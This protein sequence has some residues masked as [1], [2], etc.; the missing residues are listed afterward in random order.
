MTSVTLKMLALSYFAISLVLTLIPHVIWLMSWI[1]GKCF[2]YSLP[3]SPFGKFTLA[4]LA[5]T[6]LILCYGVFVGR[7]K[8]RTTSFDY[9]NSMVPSEFD[10][11]RVV[12]I[13]DLHLSTFDDGKKHLEKA[14]GMINAL[15]ADLVCF[16]GDM[17][18]LSPSETEPYVDVL[19]GVKARDG[20]VSVLGN[21]DFFIYSMAKK[22]RLH[23]A[24]GVT[25]DPESSLDSLVGFERDSLGWRLLRNENM[26]ISRGEGKI[27]IVGVDNI[28]GTDQG[29]KTIAKG[30]LRKAMEGTDGFR[31][32]LSHDPSHWS[33]EVVPTTDIP[34]T[35]SGHTHAAQVRIFGW[36]P[37]KWVFRHTDGRYDID[38]Q[39]LYVNIG[40]GG[41][42]PLRIGANPEI[43]LITLR[44]LDSAE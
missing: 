30:D 35:L 4:L 44:H 22:P 41:T 8:V 13:S 17:V 39:T 14:V 27:T 33:S 20:V 32:L 9:E 26:T 7:W 38:G 25:V 5:L 23:S 11:Y 29:F 37:S 12:H 6:L 3:Y 1:I 42:L 16:T 2:G 21:H 43:T 40:L 34:L 19:K 28:N 31:I 24:A 36:T 18:S 10:G 15:D